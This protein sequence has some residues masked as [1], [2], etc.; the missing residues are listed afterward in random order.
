MA[1]LAWWYRQY[2][3]DASLGVLEEDARQA[4]RGLWADPNP[5]PPW[6]VRQPKQG[7]TPLAHGGHSSEPVENPDTT[8]MPIIGN[9]N[10]HVYHRPRLP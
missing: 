7:R 2:S 1:G 3:K 9:R 4:R 8:P 10:S 6:E 5:V